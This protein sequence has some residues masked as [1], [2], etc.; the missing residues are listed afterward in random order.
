MG[1]RTK[2]VFWEEV[3]WVCLAVK[4]TCSAERSSVHAC[5]GSRGKE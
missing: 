4:A 1:G 2:S 5:E 3:V